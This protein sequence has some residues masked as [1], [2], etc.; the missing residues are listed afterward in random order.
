MM[1]S[2]KVARA[3]VPPI[4]PQGAR[5]PKNTYCIAHK[6]PR[7]SKTWGLG[8]HECLSLHHHLLTVSEA[9]KKNQLVFLL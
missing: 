9:A 8:G 2:F 7:R 3:V 6:W 1:L 5:N 4:V